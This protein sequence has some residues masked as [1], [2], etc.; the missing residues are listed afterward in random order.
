[1][2]FA[3]TPACERPARL[4][5][6]CVLAMLG[7][8]LL[9]A[10]AC[11]DVFHLKSGGRLE[12]ELLDSSDG[13]YRIRTTLGIVTVEAGAVERVE[14]AATPFPEYEKRR[15]AVVDSAA[16]HLKLARWCEEQELFRERGMHLRRALELEPDNPEVRAALG[17]VRVGEMWV[18]GRSLPAEKPEKDA[19]E[20][21]EEQDPEKLVRQI[22][23]DWRRRLSAIRRTLLESSLDRQVEKG[24][25][26]VR[27][28]RDPL[29]IAP[30]AQELGEGAELSRLLL[31][32]AL[33]SFSE[34]A[35][36]INLTALAIVDPSEE[37]RQRA[38]AELVRRSDTRVTAV[39]REALQNDDDVIVLRAAEA[40]GVL[41]AK[42]AVPEL[43]SALKVRKN[44]LVEVPVNRYFGQLSMV[45]RGGRTNVGSIELPVVSEVALPNPAAMIATQRRMMRVTVFRTEVREALHK[46]T[47]EDF[48]FD[49]AAWMRWYE[50]N[51]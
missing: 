51:R 14:K 10:T 11:A 32:E 15:E 23:G 47:G 13:R 3:R 7:I 8:A 18:S 45:F 25:Q 48:G 21:E 33:S 49:G 50:E 43:I 12:G 20:A 24:V 30:L 31:V 17:Y 1:M 36:T 2:R 29:A 38:I 28:I 40:L 37:V 42:E 34:D 27:E 44:K 5:N 35:A 16:D 26:L 39:F 41:R 19:A 6:S 46:I 9:A 4:Q 22:Q